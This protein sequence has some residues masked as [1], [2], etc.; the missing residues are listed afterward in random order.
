MKSSSH[1]ESCATL[2]S[3][4]FTLKRFSSSFLLRSDSHF[5]SLSSLS[6]A[7]STGC[8]MFWVGIDE[9]TKR[10]F[11]W[12]AWDRVDSSVR[13]ICNGIPGSTHRHWS[14]ILFHQS[15]P[16]RRKDSIDAKESGNLNG[17][18]IHWAIFRF[19]L[20]CKSESFPRIRLTR[21]LTELHL[22][23]IVRM[24]SRKEIHEPLSWHHRNSLSIIHSHKEWDDFERMESETQGEI[25][26]M[27]FHSGEEGEQR[28]K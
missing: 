20:S 7:H 28:E 16:K 2:S 9:I 15:L 27:M 14:R 24:P 25:T 22:L 26:K 12:L 1:S 5:R 23:A 11:E 8:H 17:N 18:F 3:K 6:P 19:S 10:M 13:L 21:T 4:S